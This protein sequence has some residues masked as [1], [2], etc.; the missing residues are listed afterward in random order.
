MW[1]KADALAARHEDAF[2]KEA[3]AQF[4]LDRRAVLAVIGE[5]KRKSLQRKAAIQWESALPDIR[6]VLTQA[7]DRWREAFTPLMAGVV[8]DAAEHW[9]VEAGMTFDV[10]N[11][12]AEQWFVDH[13]LKFSQPLI[14]TSEREIAALLQQGAREGW[15]VPQMQDT[16]TQMFEQWISG[17]V[18]AAD[19]AGERLPPWRSEAIARTSTMQAYNAGSTE[20]YRQNSVKARE[21]LA[22]LDDRA[23]DS[24]VEANGQVVD[25]DAPFAVGGYEL[26]FPGDTSLGADLGE[27]VNCRCTV[28][29]VLEDEDA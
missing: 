23:R 8:K 1:I 25:I 2:R 10:R 24:H 28:I 26:M 22:T 19:F 11:L 13:A 15:S 17:N 16:L 29:P 3:A 4:A 7:G 20:I 21:W 5:A 12:E 27:I 18:D 6:D 14:D 9:Q